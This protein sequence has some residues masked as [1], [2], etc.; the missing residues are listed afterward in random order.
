MRFETD[1]Q[2]A[3]HTERLADANAA[4]GAQCDAMLLMMIIADETD[5]AAMAKW[6]QYVEGTDLEALA[7]RDS[8]AAADVKAEAHSTVGRMVRFDRV[9]TDMLRLI[10]HYATVAKHLD[11]LAVIPGLARPADALCG[12]EGRL[13]GLVQRLRHFVELPRCRSCL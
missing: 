8:Q 10:G 9:P 2:V 6:N 1:S 4:A 13:S 11:A 3:A 7:W 12:R 5:E